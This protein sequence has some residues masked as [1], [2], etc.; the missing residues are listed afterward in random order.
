M[1][2][3]SGTTRLNTHA[4]PYVQ[5][6]RKLEDPGLNALLQTG[7]KRNA[8]KNKKKKKKAPA[9]TDNNNNTTTTT[10]TTTTAATPAATKTT[11]QSQMDTK[12]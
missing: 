11:E 6:D 3:P 5:S 8:K 12:E 10:T 7:T 1:V 2:L 4:L 9:A